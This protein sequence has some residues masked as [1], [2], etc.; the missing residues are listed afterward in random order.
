MAQ[1]M[2]AGGI[3]SNGQAISEKER[4]DLMDNL[5][6]IMEKPIVVV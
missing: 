2:L 1:L 5:Q 3:G 4:K 6:K